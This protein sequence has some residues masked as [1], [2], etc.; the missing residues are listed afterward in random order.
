MLSEISNDLMLIEIVLSEAYRFYESS[1][2][3]KF[4]EYSNRYSC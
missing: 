3:V 4:F 1:G 2:S